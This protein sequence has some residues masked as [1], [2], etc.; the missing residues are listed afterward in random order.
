MSNTWNTSSF[1]KSSFTCVGF[2]IIKRLKNCRYQKNVAFLQTSKIAN[3]KKLNLMSSFSL[4]T[5]P[6]IFLPYFLLW[7]I[8]LLLCNRWYAIYLMKVKLKN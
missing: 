3:S 8:L 6:S 1:N 4:I 7:L 5:S 2:S